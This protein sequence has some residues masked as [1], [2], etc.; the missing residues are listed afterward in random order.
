MQ[1]PTPSREHGLDALR[2]AATLLVLFHHTAITYGAIGGWFYREVPT[3][4]HLD[5]TLL[6]FFCAF[7]QAF[8]MG[9]FFL[10]AGYF[11]PGAIARHGPA[12]FAR[13][14]LLRLGLPLL[15]F[16]IVIGPATIALA[17]TADGAPF[18]PTLLHLWRTHQFEVGPLWFAEAL[19]IFAAAAL[20]WHA[21]ARHAPLPRPFPSTPCLAL[22]ALLTGAAAFALRLLWP[23][24][25]SVAGLQLG[26]FASY[27]VLFAAGYA[28]ASSS[29]LSTVPARQARI[30]G[31]VAWCAGPIL[32]ALFL[33]APHIPAL[34]GNFSGGWNLPALVYAFWEPL[35]AWGIILALLRS[36]SRRFHTLGPIWTKLTRRAYAIYVIH[37]P[38]LVAISLAWRT[39]AAP[40]LLK[41]AV[42]GS[43]T[44]IACYLL[45]GAILQL[46]PLRR[47]L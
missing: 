37:P 23:V 9:L 25:V 45:A 2:A 17:H 33:L 32:P 4:S 1:R 29:W 18:L 42:T 7:N 6:V 43:V 16:W 28:G 30:W 22:A 39:I 41:F 47:V 31:I 46:P 12:A 44:C 35:I 26:Y 36:F 15:T 19:L 3:D 21:R 34:A 13:E 8:F 10:L 11:T 14:R 27:I 38:V 20:I 40:H 5:T 24:G